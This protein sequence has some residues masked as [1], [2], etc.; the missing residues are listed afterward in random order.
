MHSHADVEIITCVREGVIT[1][2]DDLGN[3]GYTRAGDVQVMSAGT[4]IQHS[5][6]NEEGQPTRILHIWIKPNHPGGVP[7]WSARPFPTADRAGRFVA[8][9]S[10]YGAPS[11][12]PIRAHAEVYGA[13]LPAGVTTRLD[14]R[15]GHAAYL[16]PAVGSVIVN[17]VRVEAREGVALHD[18]P[19]IAVKALSDSEVDLVVT[20]TSS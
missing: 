1:R 2:E 15:D 17:E 4:G 3:T 8:L 20:L 19:T 12:L 5:E 7:R 10:G 9:A 13:M 11:A 18:E 14:P 16:V 6:R